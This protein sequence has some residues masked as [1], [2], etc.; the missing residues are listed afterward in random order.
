[1]PQEVGLHQREAWSQTAEV[2]QGVSRGPLGPGELGVRELYRSDDARQGRACE[3]RRSDEAADR[4]RRVFADARLDKRKLEQDELSVQ[5]A[6]VLLACGSA[7]LQETRAR[8]HDA[9]AIQEIPVE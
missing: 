9:A 3:E 5:L 8:L 6:H 2:T 4:N 7:R 1:L